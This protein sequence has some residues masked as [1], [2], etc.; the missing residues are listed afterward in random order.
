MAL[1]QER[2]KEVLQILEN[3]DM[4][5]ALYMI[6]QQF[7]QVFDLNSF[8]SI[9]KGYDSIIVNNE[10]ESPAFEDAIEL[11]HTKI[12]TFP[13]DEQKDVEGLSLQFVAEKMPKMLNFFKALCFIHAA[14]DAKADVLYP[15]T[16]T[17]EYVDDINPHVFKT[18]KEYWDYEVACCRNEFNVILPI[19]DEIDQYVENLNGEIEALAYKSYEHDEL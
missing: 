2:I 9:S 5:A 17:E 8:A 3:S 16:L 7:E 19:D 10:I 13:E 1:S 15:I 18:P 6:Q 12:S 4:F 14:H 11:I